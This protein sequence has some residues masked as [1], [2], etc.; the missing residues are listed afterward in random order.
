MKKNLR[1]KGLGN[2]LKN[3]NSQKMSQLLATDSTHQIDEVDREAGHKEALDWLL[4][5][6]NR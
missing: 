4:G 5:S 6:P 3:E 1:L 2:T